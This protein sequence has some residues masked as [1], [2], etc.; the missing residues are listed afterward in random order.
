METMPQILAFVLVLGILYI[1]DVVA[2]RTKAWIPSVFVCASLFI[3]GYWTFFPKEI[4]AMAGIPT[5][6]A[7]TVM[8]IL[9]SNMGTLLSVDELIRQW[10]TVVIV[11][12]SIV[13][14]CIVAGG[15]GMLLFDW[16]TVIIGIPP[17]VGGIVSASI[18]STGA[19]EAG[20]TSL[21]VFATILYVMQGFAGYPLTAIMLQREGRRV[22]KK[23]RA[24][25]WKISAEEV[26]SEVREM[27]SSATM[28]SMFR[29]APG[30]YNTDYFKLFRLGVVGLLAYGVSV[31]AAPVV[32][33]SPFVLC[34]V[35]GV[36][37]TRVGF[38]EK[39]PLQKANSFGFAVMAL[40][41]FIFDTLKHATPDMLLDL[42]TPIVVLIACAVIGMAITSF[43]VGKILGVNPAM[44]FAVSLT[45]LYGFPADYVITVEAINSLTKDP[46]ERQ[47][48]TNHMLGSMLVGGFISV[49]MVS[50]VLAGVLVG[51]IKVAA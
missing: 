33:I 3:T 45:A 51:Y 32:K 29:F 22:L 10:K 18:M 4:V 35:F 27:S 34:L 44:A 9:V 24:G 16:N 46:L 43:V 11:L 5:V 41:L 2:V 42:V 37:A 28:P 7:I 49:T 12:S 39:Q 47:V 13:G 30:H 38:L 36:L 15:I 26:A 21:A 25:E 23:Y 19:T 40:M 20:L 50:V 48:L 8:Y 31:L 1:G 17:L 14:L 6:V